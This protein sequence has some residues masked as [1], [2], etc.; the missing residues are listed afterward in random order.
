[1]APLEIVLF[2]DSNEVILLLCSPTVNDKLGIE[3]VAEF[4]TDLHVRAGLQNFVYFVPLATAVVFHK[5]HHLQILTVRPSAFVF[6]RVDVFVEVVVQFLGGTV[7]REYADLH[8][9]FFVLRVVVEDALVL[10]RCRLCTCLLN[11]I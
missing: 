9:I 4:L 7:L 1:M 2:G 8:P 3:D 6:V 11:W 10:F 5:H